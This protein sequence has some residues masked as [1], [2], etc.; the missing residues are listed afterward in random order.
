MA[1]QVLP[2]R[3][4][5]DLVERID[6]LTVLLQPFDCDGVPMTYTRSDAAREALER[7]VSALEA[8]A[9]KRAK[10]AAQ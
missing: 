3:V 9:K 10:Q 5:P 6:A 8:K 4:T 7:G 2:V 1:R